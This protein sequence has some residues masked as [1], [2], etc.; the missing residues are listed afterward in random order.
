MRRALHPTL[1]A[2][3]GFTLLELIVAVFMV[4]VVATFSLPSVADSLRAHNLTAATRTTANHLRAVRA[5]A[6]A[7]HTRAR[8]VVGDRHLAM[9]VLDGGTWTRTGTGVELNS[10]VTVAAVLPAGG[11]IFESG[12]TTNA[13]G[14]VRLRNSRGDERVLTVSLLGIVEGAS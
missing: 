4:A 2:T 11:I 1:T 9:E 14:S 5:T 7:R 10:G 3:P 13:A 8:L 6:V 12:G